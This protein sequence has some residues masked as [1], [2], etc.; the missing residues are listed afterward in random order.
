MTKTRAKWA[1][2]YS[3]ITKIGLSEGGGGETI[4]RAVGF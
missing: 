3:Q 2:E 4:P 1:S